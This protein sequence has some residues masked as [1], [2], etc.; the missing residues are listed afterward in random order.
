MSLKL[1]RVKIPLAVGW[2]GWLTQREEIWGKEAGE[3]HQHHN[4]V[5]IATLIILPADTHLDT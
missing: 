5:S 2:P 3:E 1:C 4:E